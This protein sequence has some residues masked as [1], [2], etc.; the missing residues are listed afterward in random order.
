MGCLETWCAIAR[1][2]VRQ[3]STGEPITIKATK[4]VKFTAGKALEDAVNAA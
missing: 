4:A 1:R 3:P 2:P